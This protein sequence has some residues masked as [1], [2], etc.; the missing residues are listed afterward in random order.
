M[1]GR[2]LKSEM[3][4]NANKQLQVTLYGS[5]SMGPRNNFEG[6]RVQEINSKFAQLYREKKSGL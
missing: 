1:D 4:V 2:K 5:K 3:N 6:S